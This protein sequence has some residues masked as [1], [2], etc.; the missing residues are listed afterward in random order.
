[1]TTATVGKYFRSFLVKLS[2]IESQLGR[3]DLG[4]GVPFYAIYLS[5]LI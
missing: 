1:M 4:G 2:M 5:F 3:L